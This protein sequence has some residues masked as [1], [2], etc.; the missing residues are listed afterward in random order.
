MGFDAFPHISRPIETCFL[1]P[2][3]LRLERSKMRFDAFAHT[4]RPLETRDMLKKP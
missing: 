3:F 4:F 2:Y 1:K